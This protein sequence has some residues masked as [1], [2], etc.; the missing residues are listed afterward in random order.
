MQK[1]KI[2]EK[3]NVRMIFEAYLH[4]TATANL[5]NIRNCSNMIS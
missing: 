1:M 2:Q 4:H 5:V 3:W